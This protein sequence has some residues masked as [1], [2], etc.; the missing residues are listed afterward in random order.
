M[1][2]LFAHVTSLKPDGLQPKIIQ[3]MLSPGF[4]ELD[5]TVQDEQFRRLI[6]PAAPLSVR[7]KMSLDNQQK[8]PPKLENHAE[9]ELVRIHI[10]KYYEDQI[11]ALQ[12]NP[13]FARRQP[14]EQEELLI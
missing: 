2:A 4:Q 14:H 7:S 3:L 12:N 1:D 13:D 5:P 10:T 9:K 8:F 6:Q 11:K